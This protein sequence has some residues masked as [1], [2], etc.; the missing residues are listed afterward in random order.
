[1]PQ[2]ELHTI[3][4]NTGRRVN[5]INQRIEKSNLLLAS[6]LKQSYD[7]LSESQQSIFLEVCKLL[8]NAEEGFLEK[9]SQHKEN[10]GPG[11]YNYLLATN[12][13]LNGNYDNMTPPFDALS[14]DRA[15]NRVYN[16]GHGRDDLIKYTVDNLKFQLNQHSLFK[17]LMSV[18]VAVNAEQRSTSFS[19]GESSGYM[20]P[21]QPISSNTSAAASTPE[22]AIDEKAIPSTICEEPNLGQPGARPGPLSDQKKGRREDPS[23]KDGGRS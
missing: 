20:I 3:L 10:L 17:D 4:E 19:E 6:S 14:E 12:Q 21:R 18:E 22:R 8:N 13:R 23:G 2:V 16:A 5:Y 1:M 9:S 15:G 11:A 7:V